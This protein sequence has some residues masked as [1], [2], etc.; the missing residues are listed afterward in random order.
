MGQHRRKC[1]NDVGST[2]HRMDV[3]QSCFVQ[4]QLGLGPLDVKAEQH[5]HGRHCVRG[6]RVQLERR[7][8]LF[9]RNGQP[10]QFPRDSAQL[11]MEFVRCFA[12]ELGHNFGANHTHWCGW[13]GGPDHPDEPTG[14][15]EPS[16]TVTIP[17]V[18]AL[19]PSSMSRAPS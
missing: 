19:N 17:K 2:P 1:G 5:R 9:E 7:C 12:H 11:H 15:R 8:W 13:P 16:M 14:S 4:R 18:A 3:I 10:I 6:R